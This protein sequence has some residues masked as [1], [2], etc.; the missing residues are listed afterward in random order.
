[1]ILVVQPDGEGRT[2]AAAI[3]VAQGPDARAGVVHRTRA[4]AVAV[5]AA[6]R[7][8]VAVDVGHRVAVLVEFARGAAARAQ[9]VDVARVG[10]RRAAAA[11]VVVEVVGAEDALELRREF[12]GRQARDA[13]GAGGGAAEAGVLPLRAFDLTLQGHVA[14][15][16]VGVGFEVVVAMLVDLAMQAGGAPALELALGVVHPPVRALAVVAM[17]RVAVADVAHRG[18]DPPLAL[19]VFEARAGHVARAAEIEQQVGRDVLLERRLHVFVA[20]PGDG[21]AGSGLP[22]QAAQRHPDLGLLEELPERQGVGHRA[23]RAQREHALQAALELLLDLQCHATEVAV[24]VRESVLGEVVDGC[25]RVGRVVLVQEGEAAAIGPLAVDPGG[26]DVAGDLQAFEAVHLQRV[27][28]PFG[29]DADAVELD[30]VHALGGRGLSRRRHGVYLLLEF[31]DLGFEQLDLLAQIG[32]AVGRHGGHGQGQQH[33]HD[34]CFEFRFQFLHGSSSR[35]SGLQN[36]LNNA[37]HNRSALSRHWLQKT[38]RRSRGR[39]AAPCGPCTD[40]T[41]SRPR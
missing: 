23:T 40:S 20:V 8:R 15:N 34:A 38:L 28:E 6:Q 2:L 33:G 36:T 14:A 11:L 7:G 19:Q 13:H 30:R 12:V 25:T 9:L 37:L 21:L 35:G 3:G 24:V 10:G 1:M 5:V 26:V 27:F 39:G 18:L 41:R 16:E 29:L 4:E 22:G 17:R 32:I 31:L